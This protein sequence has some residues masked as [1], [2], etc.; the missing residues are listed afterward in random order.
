[1]N[2]SSDSRQ[3]GASA[4]CRGKGGF[5]SELIQNLEEA[6]FLRL[7][8]TDASWPMQINRRIAKIMACLECGDL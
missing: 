8:L 3:L 5:S 6:C 4:F 7:F 2:E 1:V